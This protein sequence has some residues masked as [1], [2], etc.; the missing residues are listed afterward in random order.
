MISRSFADSVRVRTAARCPHML[1]LDLSGCDRPSEL[2]PIP[3]PIAFSSDLNT[4]F[5]AA[6]VPMLVA[7]VG[8]FGETVAAGKATADATMAGVALVLSQD[9]GTKEKEAVST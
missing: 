5:P 8:L 1:V 6:A 4:E 9:D 2:A 7:G 3:Q